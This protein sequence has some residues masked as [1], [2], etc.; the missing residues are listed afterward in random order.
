M[1]TW[2]GDG[3]IS[4]NGIFRIIG[5]KTL[6]ITIIDDHGTT[7]PSPGEHDYTEFSFV[8]IHAIPDTGYGL[9]HWDLDGIDQGF[10]T[11][12]FV[13]MTEDHDLDATYSLLPTAV[14]RY[15]TENEGY[16]GWKDADTSLTGDDS[17]SG[18]GAFGYSGEISFAWDVWLVESYSSW[19]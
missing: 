4:G 11:P 10:E 8:P 15:M 14:T 2:T 3:T 6:T 17:Y 19:F 9:D 18:T 7:D 12:I 5:T 1:S 16:Q 13:E